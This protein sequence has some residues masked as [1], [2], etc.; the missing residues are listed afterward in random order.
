MNIPSRPNIFN[1]IV[2]GEHANDTKLGL[3][4]TDPTHAARR[5]TI[6][7][8]MAGGNGWRTPP[9]E[10]KRD[11]QGLSRGDRKRLAR[12]RANA[13]VSESRDRQFMH[14]SATNVEQVSFKVAA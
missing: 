10:P 12:E 14:A 5:R 11:A 2:A 7:E 9:K 8:H 1:E 6:M 4:S 13:K 3:P